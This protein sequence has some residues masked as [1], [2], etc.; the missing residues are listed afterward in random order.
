MV[1]PLTHKFKYSNL[2]FAQSY[3]IFL[4]VI[5]TLSQYAN[6]FDFENRHIQV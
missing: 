2:H 4:L 1:E 6:E 3:I 5:H